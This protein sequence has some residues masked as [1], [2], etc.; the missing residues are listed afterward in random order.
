MERNQKIDNLC[1]SQRLLKYALEPATN[2]MM[3]V[4]R[5]P[6]GLKCGC[7]CPSCKQTL[8]AKNG[9]KIREHH[10]AHHGDMTCAGARMTALHLLAQQIIEKE[11]RVMLPSYDGEYYK[12]E[13]QEYSFDMVSLEENVK[14]DDTTL[15]PDCIGTHIDDKETEHKLWIEIFVTND[16]KEEG[17]KH[18]SIRRSK[19]ACIEIDLSGLLKTD[20]SEESVTEIIINSDDK[21]KWICCPNYDKKNEDLKQAHLLEEEK[22]RKEE[23]RLIQERKKYEDSLNGIVQEWYKTKDTKF[24]KQ[25]IEEIRHYPYHGKKSD[26][27]ICNALIPR[28]DF[29]SYIDNSPKNPDGL[30][31]FYTI[32]RYYY[33]KSIVIC[34]NDLKTRLRDIQFGRT[35]LTREEMIRLE[36][37]VSLNV[38]YWLVDCRKRTPSEFCDERDEIKTLIKHY[39]SSLAIRNE[40]LMVASVIYHHIM[41]NNSK[42]FGELTGEIIEKHSNLAK[43]YLEFVK[44]QDRFPNDYVLEGRNMVS[45]LEAFV[46]NNEN[47]TESDAVQILKIAYKYVYQTPQKRQDVIVTTTDE[48]SF[49]H[50]SYL[51][52]I[53]NDREIH[54]HIY[55]DRENNTPQIY[56]PGYSLHE[57]RKRLGLEE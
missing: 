25:I 38:L 31:V 43:T 54:P 9:G 13:S 16:I 11:K 6:N 27:C 19:T 5:V 21:R 45:E 17:E 20:Y 4:D 10:F 29:L 52:T 55:E 30:E 24:A 40:V 48:E 42:T 1:E 23:D 36:E 57:I 37:L 44:S 8:S 32:M 12:K 33:N 26:F 34:Y 18:K 7:I 50:D 2:K 35:E 15:R 47:K 46:T 53:T 3:F 14:I 56:P 22:Q 28:N 41:G 39:L 49:Y 51:A